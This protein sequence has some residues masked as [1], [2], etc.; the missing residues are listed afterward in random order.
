MNLLPPRACTRATRSVLRRC[1]LDGP[2][3]RDW[4]A[5]AS[6][7]LT[8]VICVSVTVHLYQVRLLISVDVGRDASR[9]KGWAGIL[10]D[11]I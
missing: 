6:I 7:N 9:D 11:I 8:R 10:G 5:C 1:A 2:R 3:E 4:H